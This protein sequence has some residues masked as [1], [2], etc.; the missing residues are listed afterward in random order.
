VRLFDQI[1]GRKDFPGAPAV[2]EQYAT[3]PTEGELQKARND[4]SGYQNLMASQGWLLLQKEIE[5]AAEEALDRWVAG[6]NTFQDSERLAARI[7]AFKWV[8]AI[9]AA[10]RAAANALIDEAAEL[11]RTTLNPDAGLTDPEEGYL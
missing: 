2:D 4:H 3:L 10:R 11:E 1:L 8:L 9:P 5:I 6:G 7:E